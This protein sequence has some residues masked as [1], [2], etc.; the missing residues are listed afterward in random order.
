MVRRAIHRQAAS[1]V[2]AVAPFGTLPGR[3]SR[4]VLALVFGG[5][6]QFAAST[7]AGRSSAATAGLLL[8]RVPHGAVVLVAASCDQLMIDESTAVGAARH[9]AILQFAPCLVPTDRSDARI[10][11]REDVD[12]RV[13][14]SALVLLLEAGGG[15]RALNRRSLPLQRVVLLPAALL[16]TVVD[17]ATGLDT[18]ASDGVTLVASFIVTCWCR[19]R[20]ARREDDLRVHRSGRPLDGIG[21]LDHRSAFIVAYQ[22][23]SRGSR[24]DQRRGRRGVSIPLNRVNNVNFDQSFIARILNNG[25]VTIESAGQTGD[26]VFENIPDPEHVRGIIFAQVEAD[27]QR[28]SD[29]DAASLAK[30]MREHVADAS[31]AAPA[32]P[33]PTERLAALDDLKAQGL[34]DDAEYAVKRKQILDEL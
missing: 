21:S 7:M 22:S 15:D 32:P 25:I 13:E 34:I 2:A 12:P 27:E 17:A 10:V 18:C 8:N 14:C 30:A 24:S 20:H 3:R 9:E 16:W 11:A 28:D 33:S 6:S 31:P 1:I 5:S 4:R 29:R 23:G 26:S 19:N